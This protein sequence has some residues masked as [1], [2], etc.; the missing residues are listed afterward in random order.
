MHKEIRVKGRTVVYRIVP[1]KGW[2]VA[3][4]ED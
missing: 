3:V 2:A 1:G 4:K